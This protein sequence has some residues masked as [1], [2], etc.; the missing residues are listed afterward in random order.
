M[1][2]DLKKLLERQSQLAR[3]ADPF[4]HYKEL[5]AP[6]ASM[7][8]ILRSQSNPLLEA[9]ARMKATTQPLEDMAA[10]AL[11]A[12]PPAIAQQP[13]TATHM[14]D[15]ATHARLPA[16]PDRFA[17]QMKA[18]LEPIQKAGQAWEEAL[19]SFEA[20]T[21]LRWASVLEDINRQLAE[22]PGELRAQLDVLLE[23]GWF[24]DPEMPLPKSGELAAAFLE[25][26]EDEAQQWLMDYFSGRLDA[27]EQSLAKRHPARAPV[28]AQA[29]TAHRQG[30]Y[31]LSVPV[32][33]TQ[34]EGIVRDRH[35]GRQL[36]SKRAKQ[37]L[38]T[39]AGVL[40]EDGLRA[41]VIAAFYAEGNPLIRDTDTL[42]SGFDGL[43]RHAVLHG[44]DPHYGTQVNGLRAVSLLN[45]ASYL[46]W[47]ELEEA[48][49]EPTLS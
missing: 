1:N 10:K 22:W 9:Q 32:F 13:K 46:A 12:F 26:Q 42:P 33:L 23:K 19:R 29:F 44:S 15:L 40:D 6:T 5:L 49:G 37:N 31:C 45:L 39:L 28:L 2:D 7:R 8:E 36:F 27:I 20:R 16:L 43:N 18:L 41:I 14:A 11:A 48:V 47:E 21:S 25:G 34:A 4:R 3:L 30:L 24:L 38:S 35:D 17:E